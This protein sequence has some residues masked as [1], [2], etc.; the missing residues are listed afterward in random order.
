MHTFLKPILDIGPMQIFE[1][2]YSVSYQSLFYW[3][4]KSDQALHGPFVSI[5]EA[6]KDYEQY[7]IASREA[8][9]SNVVHVNFRTKK[10]IL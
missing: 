6:T 8:R 9:S 2:K 5:F 1:D 10:R 3:N 7:Y 4:L